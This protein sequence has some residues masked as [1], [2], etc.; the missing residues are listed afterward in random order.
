M[1]II[2]LGAPGVGKGT[3][4]RFI[5]EKYN[6]PHI[7]IGNILRNCISNH[8]SIMSQKIKKYIN[9][10]LMVPDNITIQ[11]IKKR[12]SNIDCKKGFLL[13]GYP[14]NIIQ[15]NILEKENIKI[16]NII[17]IYIPY[18][19]IITRILGRR[20]HDPSGRTYHVIFN[21]PK[22][23]GK[24]DITGEPLIRRIDDNIQTI[25]YRLKEY[26]KQTQ[27]LIQY[28]RKQVYKKDFL[29]KKINNTL[30]IIEV[31]NEID[32][33]LQKNIR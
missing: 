11:I 5:S 7:S 12:L 33:F 4:A 29:Y 26:F 21:P 14:R 1:R 32:H 3:H 30:S 22:I 6:L 28:Y 9:N 23:F 20:I 13:D 16:D 10:G 27:P 31:K 19:Q 8:D 15:A 2:L 25:N 24:D 17:E 18:S